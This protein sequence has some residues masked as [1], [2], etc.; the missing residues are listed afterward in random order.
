M[1]VRAGHGRRLWVKGWAPGIRNEELGIKNE[2]LEIKNEELEI[3][4]RRWNAE[5]L[6]I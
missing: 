3:R 6:L 5:L 4:L 2:E 1:G